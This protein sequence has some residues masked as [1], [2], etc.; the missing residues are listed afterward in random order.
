MGFL[1]EPCALASGSKL[2]LYTLQAGS[3]LQ[4]LILSFAQ[5]AAHAIHLLSTGLSVCGHRTRE[6]CGSNGPCLLS[7]GT[8]Q[9]STQLRTL[10]LGSLGS[11]L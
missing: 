6:L 11:L 1:V 5:A 4:L 10:N 9:F 8:G 2:P 3:K 7:S